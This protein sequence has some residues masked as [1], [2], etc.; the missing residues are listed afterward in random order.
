VH[1]ELTERLGRRP[2][3]VTLYEHP[4]VA[5]LARHLVEDTGLFEDTGAGQRP[6]A[7]R[8]GTRREG[9]ARQSRRR[10]IQ[11]SPDDH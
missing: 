7:G 3:M 8:A 9:T 2:P 1:A 11:P 6:D 10:R 5:S 4:T